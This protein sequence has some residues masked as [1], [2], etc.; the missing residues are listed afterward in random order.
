MTQIEAYIFFTMVFLAIALS[1]ISLKNKQILWRIATF[2]SWF[3]LS[4]IFLTNAF[5]T[6]INDDWTLYLGWIF[7]I[8]SF[9]T[10]LM[11]MDTEITVEKEGRSW[12]EYGQP[13]KGKESKYESYRRQLYS[14]TRRGG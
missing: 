7:L 3:T 12:K 8:I 1:V 5:G 9:A 13:P 2:L 4:I 11:H 6:S 14:K 10:L